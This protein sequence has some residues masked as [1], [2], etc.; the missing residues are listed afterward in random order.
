MRGGRQHQLP[1]RPQGGSNCGSHFPRERGVPHWG[2]VGGD[3]GERLGETLTYS[4][5]ALDNPIVVGFWRQIECLQ[6]YRD[7]R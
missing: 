4:V 3:E 1:A 6:R 7:D 5:I 2:G